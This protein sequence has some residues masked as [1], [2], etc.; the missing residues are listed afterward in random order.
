MLATGVYRLCA[1]DGGD[2]MPRNGMPLGELR[3]G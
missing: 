1:L 3:F 2:Q